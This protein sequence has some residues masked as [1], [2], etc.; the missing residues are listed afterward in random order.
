MIEWVEDEW[1]VI[2]EYLPV[3]RKYIKNG[4]RYSVTRTEVI[5]RTKG[6]QDVTMYRYWVNGHGGV[7]EFWTDYPENNAAV[8]DMLAVKYKDV[9]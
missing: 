3:H 4:Y 6:P 9:Q 8:V 7:I 5:D 1:V 2:K